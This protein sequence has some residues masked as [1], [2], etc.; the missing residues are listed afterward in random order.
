MNKQYSKEERKELIVECKDWMAKGKSV[1]SFAKDKGVPSGTLYCW[2][3]GKKS[4]KSPSKKALVHI[5]KIQKM[6]SATPLLVEMRYGGLSFVFNEGYSQ[7]SL[8][9][10]LLSL[11]KCGLL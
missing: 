11:K 6:S 8:E 1:S 4:S 7:E 9:V 10:T 3:S 5:P 2:M